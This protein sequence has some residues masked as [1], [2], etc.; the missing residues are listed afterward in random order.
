MKYLKALII[1]TSVCMLGSC[2][3]INK[4]NKRGGTENADVKEMKIDKKKGK[5]KDLTAPQ[6]AA[7]EQGT[8]PTTEQL[9]GGRWTIVSIGDT[10]INAEDEQPY[11][12]FDKQGRFYA[13][14]GCNVVNGDYTIRS[15]GDMAFGNV[16]ST[17]KYC[18]DVPYAPA[19]GALLADGNHPAIDCRTIGQ[20]TYLYFNDESGKNIAT[21]RRHNMEFLNGNW[22][23][24]SAEGKKIND[25]EANIFIDVAELKVHGNT[26]CNYF[27]GELY[28]D[29]SRSNAVDFSNMGLTRMACPK[30][31]QE[32]RIMVALEEAVSAIA[33]KKEGTVLLLNGQGKE[34]MILKQKPVGS[35]E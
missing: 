9:T 7:S 35:E 19:I 2:S 14:D 21:Y 1:A 34:V 22:A 13:S 15:N 18:P 30:A 26:G 3:L 6:Y 5:V 8:K 24:I 32:R 4:V 25:E 33:G 12:H 27:N 29:P 10:E 28:I 11:I 20:D 16:L 31:D 23:I 17:M